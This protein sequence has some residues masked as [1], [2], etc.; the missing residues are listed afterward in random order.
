MPQQ[1]S[2]VEGQQ[3]EDNEDPFFVLLEDDKVIYELNVTTD[4]LFLPPEEHEPERD[5]FAIIRVRTKTFS[6][7][8]FNIHDQG[9]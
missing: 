3:P 8:R 9:G 5:V 2:E 4:R 1:C 7:D 6:G